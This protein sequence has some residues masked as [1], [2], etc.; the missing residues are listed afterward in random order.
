MSINRVFLKG[1]K[2]AALTCGKKHIDQVYMRF[3]VHADKCPTSPINNDPAPP[4]H[5][6]A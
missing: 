3:L 2:K 1:G 5:C 6:D 4:S